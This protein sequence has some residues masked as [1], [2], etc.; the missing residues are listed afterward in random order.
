M[1]KTENEQIARAV[2]ALARLRAHGVRVLFVR[3]PSAGPYLAYEDRLYPRARAWDALL[4]ATHAPGIY[5]EDYP[6]LHGYDLP[7]WSHMT[8]AEAERFTAALY[9]IIEREF[10]GARTGEAERSRRALTRSSQEGFLLQ[11][12]GLWLKPSCTS[13]DFPP[14]RQ[15]RRS[16][17]RAIGSSQ[18][19]RHCRARKAGV[20]SRECRQ[21]RQVTTTT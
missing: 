12:R 1:L 8:R 4:N 10:W 17:T 2:K 7:E 21:A 3:L 11:P 18:P 20:S 13:T 14:Q 16:T 19:P 6:Q 15:R 5:F 9:G